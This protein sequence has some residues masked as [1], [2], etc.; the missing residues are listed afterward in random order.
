MKYCTFN[1]KIVLN[2]KIN[3]EY[4]FKLATEPYAL[5]EVFK[6]ETGKFVF[7]CEGVGYPSPTL[8]WQYKKC[9]ESDSFCEKIVLTVIIN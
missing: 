3:L 4:S 9:E 1:L 6:L 7:N 8:E 2:L 5:I